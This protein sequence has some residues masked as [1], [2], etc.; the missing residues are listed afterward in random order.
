MAEIKD[1]EHPQ[2]R[3]DRELT[4]QLLQAQPDNTLNLAELARLR[5]R[6]CGFPGARDIQ[7][8]LDVILKQWQMTEEELFAKTRQIHAEGPVYKGRASRHD[9]EDWS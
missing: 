6:Y 1:Q 9:Q 2:Y 5:I 3:R 8:D 7:K 4:N